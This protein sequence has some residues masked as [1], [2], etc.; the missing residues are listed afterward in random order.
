MQHSFI[1]GVAAVAS[2]HQHVAA[3]VK[4]SLQTSARPI[5]TRSAV[6]VANGRL[7]PNNSKNYRRDALRVKSLWSMP[8]IRSMTTRAVAALATAAEDAS[9]S[10]SSRPPLPLLWGGM[11][12][13]AV[14]GAT[15]DLQQRTNR[16]DCCGIIGVVA[17]PGFDTR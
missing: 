12:A 16:T 1:K 9:S 2:S 11:L 3:S 7:S 17:K 4:R 10:S 5:T 14:A 6:A 15:W 13:A 8:Q